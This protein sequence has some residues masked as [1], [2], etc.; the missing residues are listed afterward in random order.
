LQPFWR[1][2]GH[3]FSG[4][5]FWRTITLSQLCAQY[6]CLLWTYFVRANDCKKYFKTQELQKKLLH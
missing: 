5:S 1:R 6:I 2:W 4:S 3:H